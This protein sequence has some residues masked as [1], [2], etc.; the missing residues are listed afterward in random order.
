MLWPDR[1][2][3]GLT[4]SPQAQKPT[5]IRLS[6]NR[7]FVGVQNLLDE[8]AQLSETHVDARLSHSRES[9]VAGGLQ[10]RGELRIEGDGEG[11]VDDVAVH[12]RSEVQ[13]HHVSVVE[14]AR[15]AGVRRVV[16]CHVV[17]GHACGKTHSSLDENEKEDVPVDRFL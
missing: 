8:S 9:S 2:R 1:L 12:L 14:T 7:H 10:E 5:R 13:L 17:H 16:R 11:G 4:T 3:I 6:V 15:V